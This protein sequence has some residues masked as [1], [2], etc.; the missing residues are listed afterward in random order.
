MPNDN[1]L[2]KICQGCRSKKLIE[3]FAVSKWTRDGLVS[4]CRK[5]ML[6]LAKVYMKEKK[7]ADPAFRVSIRLRYMFENRFKE[8]GLDRI[9]HGHPTQDLGCTLKDLISYIE[10]RM[11]SGMTWDNR[12]EGLW[13]IDH[14]EP[15]SS[16]DLTDREQFLEAWHFTNLQPLWAED[17]ISKGTSWT[18][19]EQDDR[20]R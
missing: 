10:A 13:H 11:F 16:F 6:V 17:N 15:L 4:K 1:P 20:E 14:R 5:C 3:R 18:E 19:P 8:L 12:A 2:L 7:K 9:K